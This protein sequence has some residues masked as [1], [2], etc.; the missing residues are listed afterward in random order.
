MPRKEY[1]QQIIQSFILFRKGLA[2]DAHVLPH[3]QADAMFCVFDS[4]SITV[5]ELAHQLQVTPGAAT[6][7]ADSL[8]RSGY[9]ER[10]TDGSDRRV[11]RI[12]LSEKGKQ[13]LQEAKKLKL[14][15]LQE[16][17][18]P[19]SDAEVQTLAALLKKVSKSIHEHKGE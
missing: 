14:A 9:I 19:L 3:A 13:A 15:K 17:L 8:T 6:Q 1:I 7:L 2:N 12:T 5:S 11:T 18:A 16:V 10:E 4:G